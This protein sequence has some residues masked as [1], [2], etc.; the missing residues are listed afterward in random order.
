MGGSTRGAVGVYIIISSPSNGLIERMHHTMERVKGYPLTWP[1]YVD[2]YQRVLNNAVHVSTGVTPFYAFYEH[3]PPRR[4]TV[5]LPTP[6]ATEM[7]INIAEVVKEKSRM[8]QQ[9][10]RDNPNRRR[11]DEQVPVDVLVWVRTETIVPGTCAKLSVPW[12]GPYRVKEV[13]Q[14]GLAY[15]LKDSYTGQ[16]LHRAAEKIKPYVSRYE[17]VPECEEQEPAQEK[18]DLVL[19]PRVRRP[20]RQ[21]IEEM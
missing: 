17:I 19:P 18:E 4:V 21:L 6:P 5:P 3:H 2:K 16:V 10:Y 8:S 12:R 11:R 7:A 14:S 13:F 15:D 1:A 9:K 20:A